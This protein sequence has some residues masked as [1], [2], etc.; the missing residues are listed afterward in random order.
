MRELLFGGIL[1][2]TGIAII[3]VI[4]PSLFFMENGHWKEFGIGR[5]PKSYTWM[6]FWLFCI[7]WGII[8]YSTVYLIIRAVDR[9]SVVNNNRNT[10]AN[11]NNNAMMDAEVSMLPGANTARTR[12][13][14][15]SRLPPA[16]G[17]YVLRNDTRNNSPYYEYY[18]NNG[19]G[20]SSG[21]RMT[22]Y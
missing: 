2:L 7:F 1:Y 19:N 6:P 5:N 21:P 4:K 18:S 11:H 14:R 10:N 15:R 3:L 8:S 12:G 20:N 16:S 22:R 17:Y 9:G 13:L